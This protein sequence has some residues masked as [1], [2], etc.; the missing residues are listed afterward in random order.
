[1]LLTQGRKRKGPGRPKKHPMIVES[2][3]D[4]SEI[5][6]WSH[7]HMKY[8][9]RCIQYTHYTC[10][11]D[12]ITAKLRILKVCLLICTCTLVYTLT[13]CVIYVLVLIH[14]IPQ[15]PYYIAIHSD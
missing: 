4:E 14:C 10:W 12:L 7:T 3:N 13:H 5:V 15:P 6:C 11:Y 2:D 8:L 1:M 9:Y